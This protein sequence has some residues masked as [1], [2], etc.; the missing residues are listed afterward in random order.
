MPSAKF[1]RINHPMRIILTLFPI[2]YFSS[3]KCVHYMDK[4][5]MIYTDIV[6]LRR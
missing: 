3:D 4:F 2:D 1:K 5:L 6:T